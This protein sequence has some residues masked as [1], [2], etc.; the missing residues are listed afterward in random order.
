[1]P[2][3]LAD[4]FEAIT[5]PWWPRIVARYNDNEVRIAR[6]EGAYVWHSHRATDELFLVL[7]GVLHLEL[8]DR[9][10]ILHPGDLFVVPAG[11]EHRP[12]V[13]TGEVR[14]LL[15]DR[16]GEPT[17]GSNEASALTRTDLPE[18]DR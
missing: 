17:T 15:M 18:D 13:P 9:T 2:I 14:V 1:M 4:R 3:T 8:R 6:L 5:E 7:E 12:V 16:E 10:E 11:T